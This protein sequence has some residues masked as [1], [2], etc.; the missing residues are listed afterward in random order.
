MTERNPNEPAEEVTYW[1]NEIQ[2]CK[3]REEGFRKEGERILDIYSG[4]KASTTPFNILFSNTETLLPA[5]YSSVPRPVVQRRFK[6]ADPLGKNASQAGA[7]VLEFL[8]DTNVDGYETFDEGMRSGV[9]DALLP[10]RGITCVKYDAEVDGGEESQ[11]KKSELVCLESRVWNKVYFGYA[12]KWSKVPWI[13]YEE[14]IDKEEAIRLFGE[15]VTKLIVFTSEKEDDDTNEDQGERKTACIYQIWDKAG[16]KKVRYISPQYKEGYLKEDDDPLG[17]TGFFNCPKPI[18]FIEKSHDLLPVALYVL[19]ENQAKELNR[20]TVRIGKT[21]EAIKARGAY[22][23]ELG[24]LLSNIMKGDDNELIPT[25]KTSSL[26][27]EK[28]LSNA[29]WFMPIE[30]LIAV[31]MQLNVARENCKNVIYE[32]TGIADIMRGSTNASETLGAQQIKQSWGTLRLKRL[33]KEVQRYSR[34]LLRMMLEIAATKFSEET[35]AKM[36]GMPFMTADKKAQLDQLVFSMKSAQTQ[37]QPID[38]KMQEQVQQQMQVP[39]WG[40]VIKLL[41]DDMQRAYRI[42]IET[43]ST[44][45]PEAVEDQKNITELMTAIGQ[46]LNGVGPLVAQGTL[47]FEVASSMLMAIT[48]RF[49]FGP[50]IEDQIAQM[51]AP[52]P[53]DDGKAQAQAEQQAVQAQQQAQMQ[54]AQGKM[55]MDQAK[56]QADGQSKA[57]ELQNMKEI[58]NMRLQ[59]TAQA[60]QMKADNALVIQDKQLAA[61]AELKLQLA[62]IDRQTKLEIAQITAQTAENTAAHQASAQ[63]DTAAMSTKESQSDNELQE[64]KKEMQELIALR[65]QPIKIDRHPDGRAKSVNGRAVAYSPDGRIEAIH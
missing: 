64:L 24:E 41:Q 54:I 58:E 12:K 30:Q 39:V 29:I 35:W 55:Q 33:Q 18:Q 16:G 34:D 14:Q 7:R 10:G 61:E 42:D 56:L 46:Y 60:E 20:L 31:L 51:K 9:L 3:K 65:S 49:R 36:T 15:D 11:Y 43:N 45:E 57:A 63:R 37:G 2:A 27:A 62:A 48:R 25:D 52:P 5:L 44:V 8:V 21:I 32:I 38:P 6:D 4:K 22:D 13:A 23:G 40:D 1:L 28:G 50:E 59:Y 17:L 19:Y 47:P 26:A 53:P